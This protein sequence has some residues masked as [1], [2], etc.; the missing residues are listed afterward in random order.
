MIMTLGLLSLAIFAIAPAAEAA[1]YYYPTTDYQY[2]TTY[3]PSYSYTS[4]YGYGNAMTQE[5]LISYL[6][7]LI[8]QLQAQ[9]AARPGYNYYG[10]T[11]DHNYVIGDPRSSD[12]DDDDNNDGDEPEVETRSATDIQE[13]EAALRGRVD[14]NDFEDGE[15]FFVYGTDDDQV[16]DVADDY[17]TYSDIDTDGDDLSKIRVDS[18]LDDS[19][20]YEERVTGLD[21]DTRYYFAICVGY[22]DEDEDDVLT[23]DSADDFTTDN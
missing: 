13:D 5:Q 20:S 18:S 4:T 14:M 8:A 3:N 12:D 2:Q 16:D 21:N 23:C 10:G 17:D 7:T 1:N 19:D 22:E 9:L 11:Y 6:R 15:V